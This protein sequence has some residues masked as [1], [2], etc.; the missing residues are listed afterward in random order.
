M[1]NRKNLCI[2][3]SSKWLDL[4]KF[5]YDY[6]RCRLAHFNSQY[7]DG[8]IK[9]KVSGCD[10]SVATIRNVGLIAHID[11]GKTTTTERMLYYARRTHH[12]GEV[13]HGNTVT[14]YLP[15]ERE[16]GISIVTSAASLSWRSHVINLL[17]T[18]GHVDFTFEVERSLT[19]LDSGRCYIGCS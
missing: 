12:L 4:L 3:L 5:K 2:L 14:D 18:P 6:L 15:E 1:L 17:D 16:R 10:P 9:A 7:I 19:V 8:D 11:A 13:D